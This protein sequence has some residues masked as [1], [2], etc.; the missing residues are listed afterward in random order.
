MRTAMPDAC[1]RQG[2]LVLDEAFDMSTAGPGPA[3]RST[4][5]TRSNSSSTETRWA[6][7]R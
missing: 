7:E 6:A 2:M 3:S 1:I 4:A 5:P